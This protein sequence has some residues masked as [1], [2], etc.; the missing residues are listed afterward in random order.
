[1]RKKKNPPKSGTG[2]GV[3]RHLALPHMKAQHGGVQISKRSNKHI[4][5]YVS[6]IH[7]G[8]RFV[9]SHLQCSLNVEQPLDPLLP[10]NDAVDDSEKGKRT[11]DT[12]KQE[13]EGGHGEP[14]IR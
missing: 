7:K 14:L 13:C 5:I 3:P 8:V 2:V 10:T 1:M 6:K 9:V 12:V 11:N 4:H